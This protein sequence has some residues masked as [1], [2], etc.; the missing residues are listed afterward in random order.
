M[1][2]APEDALSCV[3]TKPILV[4]V[5]L[6]RLPPLLL[7]LLGGLGP[8]TISTCAAGHLLIRLGYARPAKAGLGLPK[9][10]STGARSCPRI[11]L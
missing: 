9:G 8:A 1:G 6:I 7:L 4:E 3:T 10:L 5:G 11:R 2:V